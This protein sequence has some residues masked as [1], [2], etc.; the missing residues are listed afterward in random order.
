MFYA[1]SNIFV[2]LIIHPF[3]IFISSC[4]FLFSN[5]PLIMFSIITLSKYSSFSYFHIY[6]CSLNVDC[7]SVVR[8]SCFVCLVYYLSFWTHSVLTFC[9]FG[10][11]VIHHHLHF[12]FD[13]HENR[14]SIS[15]SI[16]VV[17]LRLLGY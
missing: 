10:D 3:E 16:S 8:V 17:L 13:I 11:V 6:I 7:S 9:L 14:K 5:F 12:H 2:Q 4:I 1:L 15:S